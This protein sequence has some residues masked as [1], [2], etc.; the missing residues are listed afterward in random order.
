MRRACLTSL[1]ALLL[2]SACQTLTPP[3]DWTPINEEKLTPCQDPSRLQSGA[4]QEV[5]RWA[6]ETGSKYL[7][8]RQ[9]QQDLSDAVRLRQ[10]APKK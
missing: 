4:H 5:E 1:T 8:C 9:K 6:V 3:S 7:E 2:L 10:E